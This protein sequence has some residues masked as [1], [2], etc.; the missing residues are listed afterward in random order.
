M[1]YIHLTL[2]L[3]SIISIISF[4]DKGYLLSRFASGCPL[5]VKRQI[6][7]HIMVNYKERNVFNDLSPQMHVWRSFVD[8][9]TSY[10]HH[11]Q[12]I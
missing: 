9:G 1:A 6:F 8:V 4:A 7:E 5:N 10:F 11:A 12:S 3:S 2:F